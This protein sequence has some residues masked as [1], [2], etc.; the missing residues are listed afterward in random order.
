MKLA[1]FKKE[2]KF[3][4][5]KHIDQDFLYNPSEFWNSAKFKNL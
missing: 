3:F 1:K 5:K 4:F 2:V